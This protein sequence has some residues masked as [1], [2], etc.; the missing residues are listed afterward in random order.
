[1]VNAV[2]ELEAIQVAGPVLNEPEIMS[3]GY[4]GT[5]EAES[6]NKFQ[7]IHFR[8]RKV[9]DYEMNRRRLGQRGHRPRAWA[10]STG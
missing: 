1:M 10:A 4:I 7:A 5:H 6:A 9:S 8:H 2:Q 3:T